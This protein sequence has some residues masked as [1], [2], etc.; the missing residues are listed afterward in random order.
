MGRRLL[1]IVILCYSNHLTGVS[2][3]TAYDCADRNANYST[4]SLVQPRDCPEATTEYTGPTSKKFQLI[5][6]TQEIDVIGVRCRVLRTVRVVPCG[7]TWA[8]FGGS[9][10]YASKHT[11]YEQMVQ[12]S[13]MDCYKAYKEGFINVGEHRF[14]TQLG[15][16]KK[17]TKI[18]QGAVTNDGSCTTANFHSANGEYFEDAYEETHFN[19]T[20]NIIV[21]KRYMLDDV[22]VFP[23]GI[24]GVYQRNHLHDAEAG[25]IQ[26]ST[27]HTECPD[28]LSSAYSGE[29]EVYVKT[30]PDNKES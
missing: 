14:H 7:S 9:T 27:P 24:R 2:T 30:T 20:I 16:T 19:I 26:W 18:T 12:V 17:Y 11:A 3:F 22:V 6:D 4:I 23:P 21:G 25:T 29:V 10:T 15:V 5:Q 13:T 1:L 8:V 28:T